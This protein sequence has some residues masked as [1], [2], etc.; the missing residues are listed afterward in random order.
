[1]LTEAITNAV[2]HRDYRLP[3]DVMV[4]IFS[5]RV[6]V[7]SPGLLAGPVTTANIAEI[8]AH[9]RNPLLIQHLRQFPDPPNLDAGEGVR[10]MFK[11]MD[12]ARLYPPV[13][14]TRPRFEREAVVLCLWNQNRPS[15]WEQVSARID[16]EG[17][18]SNTDV[19]QLMGTD[20]VLAASKK[21]KGWLDSGLLVT[22]NPDAAKRYRR[23]TKPSSIAVDE[24]FPFRK[25]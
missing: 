3:V 9:S 18:I 5:D 6:E 8:G 25:G 4:R 11:T 10:M 23:Y 21:I 15:L 17:A 24:L 20:N 1:V 13:Y 16:A 2:I 22:V 12:E 19:R 7:E 14:Q